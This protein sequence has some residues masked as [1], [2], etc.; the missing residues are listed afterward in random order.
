MSERELR[1]ALELALAKLRKHDVKHDPSYHVRLV[2]AVDYARDA[3]IAHLEQG[4]AD[5]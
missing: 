3:L 1:A 2:Y 4:T 5:P